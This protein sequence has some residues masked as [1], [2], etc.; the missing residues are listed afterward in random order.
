VQTGPKKTSPVVWIVLG[1][2]GFFV[3]VGV[4]I[5]IGVGM[6]VHKVKQ[7]PAMAMAKLLTAANPDVEVLDAD[8]GHNSVKIRDKKTGET[9]SVN[10]DD[11]KNGR[12]NLRGPKGEKATINAHADGQ[13]GAVEINGPDGSVKF[14]AG[15]NAK[16]PEWIPA[17]PGATATANFSIQGGDGSGGTFSFTTKD[18]L[19]AVVAF[20]NRSLTGAGFK[21]TTNVTGTANGASGTMLSAENEA[22]KQTLVITIGT[23][24]GNTGVNVIYGTKK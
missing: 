21:I 22:T 6:F 14:G 12:I 15:A 24:S 13:N 9:I 10:F 7:N 2:V 1:I 4:V 20:Y 19:D 18:S 17:Y 8:E 23:E 3:L 11:L 16:M 5:S